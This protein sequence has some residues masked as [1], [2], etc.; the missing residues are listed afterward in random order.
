M[1]FVMRNDQ[2]IDLKICRV[3]LRSSASLPQ[4]EFLAKDPRIELTRDARPLKAVND[5]KLFKPRFP[6]SRSWLTERRSRLPRLHL[7]S[8]Q[9]H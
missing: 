2:V 8:N 7:V 3:K 5:S 4:V 1:W 9:A 6:V